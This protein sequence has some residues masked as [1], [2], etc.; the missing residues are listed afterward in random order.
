MD[1][2][3]DI[4]SLSESLINEMVGAVGLPKTAFFH[5]IFWCLFRGLSDR[6]ATQGVTFDQLVGSEGL[7]HASAWGLAKYC[8]PVQASGVGHIPPAGPLLVVSNHPGSLDGLVIF[9]QLRRQDIRWI[10]TPVSFFEMLPHLREHILFSSRT[11]A[12]NRMAVMRSGIRHLKTGGT[13]VYFGSGHRDPDPAVF[14]GAAKMTD[15][16]LE[17]ID[18]FF[19]HVPNLR[20]LPTVVSGMVSEIWAH[21]PVTILRRT[22]RDKQRLSEF[23]QSIN[24]LLF[25]GRLLLSPCVSFGP[26]TVEADLRS[27]S[28]GGS[29]LPAV[30]SR[31]KALLVEHCRSYG[32]D[33]QS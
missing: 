17:G 22:Q 7:P 31:E 12:R 8:T 18:F 33:A 32:G 14:P 24:Q 9:S 11:D 5:R 6:V 15:E 25:P 19:K 2:D 13:L 26:A 30:I 1:T 29:L 16:W 3:T 23:C 20:L 10:S 4:A 28:P 21:H 27:D